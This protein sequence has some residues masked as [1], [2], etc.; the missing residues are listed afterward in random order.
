[1]KNVNIMN[2][3]EPIIQFEGTGVSIFTEPGS[4]F[5]LLLVIPRGACGCTRKDTLNAE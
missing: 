2:T 1:M 4:F 5:S 3:L